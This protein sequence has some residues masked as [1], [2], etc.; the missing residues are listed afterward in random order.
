MRPTGPVVLDW[1]H[2]QTR[3]LLA[4][5]PVSSGRVVDMVTGTALAAR[6]NTSV[7]QTSVGPAIV[8]D[9][10]NEAYAIA[11]PT[12]MKVT[13]P[14]SMAVWVYVLGTP[15]AFAGIAGI[16]H[17][18]T[19]SAPYSSYGLG[20]DGSTPRKLILS[21]NTAGVA[22]TA[23]GSNLPSGLFH[24]VAVFTGAGTF[25]YLNGVADVTD[26]AVRSNPT[27]GA[28]SELW[29]GEGFPA[30]GRTANVA[31]LDLRLWNRALGVAEIASLYDPS[32]RWSI[33]AKPVSSRSFISLSIGQ[34]REWPEPPPAP[35]PKPV[36]SRGTSLRQPRTT[37]RPVDP[38]VN[39]G[40]P[41]AWSL[42]YSRGWWATGETIT[43]AKT[44]ESLVGRV[45]GFGATYGAATTDVVS[46]AYTKGSSERTIAAWLYANG[47]GGSSGG[48]IYDRSSETFQVGGGV[49]SLRVVVP[50]ATTT[51]TYTFSCPFSTW[52]HVAVTWSAATGETAVV[53]AY[54][55]GQSVSVTTT[56]PG[57]GAYLSLDGQTL[58]LGNSSGGTRVWDGMI[59]PFGVWNRVLSPNEVKSLWA[60]DSRWDLYWTPK[61]QI[62]V[63]SNYDPAHLP[64]VAAPAIVTGRKTAIRP[65][66]FAVNYGS[67]QAR[68]LIA[69]YPLMRGNM[70]WVTQTGTPLI[71]TDTTV[72]TALAG[73][74]ATAQVTSVVYNLAPY[75]DLLLSCWF[76][77]D[78]WNTSG[79]QL[80]EYTANWGSGNGLKITPNDSGG[81]FYLG[82]RRASA[83]YWADTFT[84][85]TASA[86]HHYL[87]R[88]D[89]NTPQNQVWVDGV[90]QTL[91]PVLH[92]G[93]GRV[94]FDN[95]T[96]YLLSRALSSALIAG[97]M[98]DLRFYD[99]LKVDPA[100]LARQT[101]DPSTR[102]DFY[103]QPKSVKMIIVPSSYPGSKLRVR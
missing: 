94:D 82:F 52:Q 98:T 71:K 74:G 68:G 96:L 92:S 21:A 30:V 90:P 25:G 26:V 37:T 77:V 70:G 31:M 10:A 79:S 24:Y 73:D 44:V 72:G 15:S 48:R 89:T 9:A 59:G 17:N 16:S 11:T 27:F 7:G 20:V 102:W 97:A 3:G 53:N 47:A 46:T 4:C 57:S 22:Y 81:K 54:V 32:N 5:V 99:G 91:T 60:P 67:P 61:S 36:Y 14:V 76:Y 87:F 65:V 35:Q 58:R 51:G 86:W 80:M 45:T 55:N 42:V 62:T 19:N 83:G 50:F 66:E 18:N 100:S 64:V 28:S 43:G 8:C 95:S 49:G 69:A 41:L 75:S 40:H 39:V 84:R 93:S 78:A 13:L 34:G 103:W 29:M 56:V 33:Y 38:V 85:P 101:S 2:P 12:S 6:G 23:L 88:L 1:G 63:P